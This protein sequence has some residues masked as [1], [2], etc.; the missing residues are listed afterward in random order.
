MKRLWQDWTAEDWSNA[1]FCPD[2]GLP[3]IMLEPEDGEDVGEEICVYCTWEEDTKTIM[4]EKVWRALE[5][6]P[7]IRDSLISEINK[8]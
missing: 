4:R 2:C 7:D 1:V 3:M 8:A 6:M 5:N